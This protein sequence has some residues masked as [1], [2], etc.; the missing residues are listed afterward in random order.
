MT[1]VQTCALPIYRALRRTYAL[2]TWPWVAMF[3]LR[4]AVQVPLYYSDDIGWLG[5][6]KLAMGLPL[7]ALALWISWLV[8]RSARPARP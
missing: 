4:L 3:A 2:A 1:G 5:T 8:V 7:T 6:A